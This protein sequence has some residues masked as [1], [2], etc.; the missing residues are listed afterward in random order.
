M[1]IIRF[2]NHNNGEVV[3]FKDIYNYTAMLGDLERYND[4]AFEWCNN[5]SEAKQFGD[6]TA[7]LYVSDWEMMFPHCT[8]E[9]IPI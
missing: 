6:Y 4:I 9:A 3:Y 1:K 5:Q 8:I 2:T 7:D